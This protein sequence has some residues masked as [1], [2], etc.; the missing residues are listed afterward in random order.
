VS[1]SPAAVS[2]PRR[3]GKIVS[4]LPP[5]RNYVL[6]LARGR[7][8]ATVPTRPSGVRALYS[9]VTVYRSGARFAAGRVR[10]RLLRSKNRPRLNDIVTAPVI[11]RYTVVRCGNTILLPARHGDL[12]V[13]VRPTVLPSAHAP[14]IR[15][16]L[17]ARHRIILSLLLSHDILCFCT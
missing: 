15:S 2:A 12:A 5:T 3:C 1:R 10:V 11:R 13:S 8:L 6:P 14:A 7:K 16:G 9:V 17:Y 4:R